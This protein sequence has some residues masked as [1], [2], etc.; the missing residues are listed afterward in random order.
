VTAGLLAGGDFDV[1]VPTFYGYDFLGRLGGKPFVLFVPDMI[2][3][4]YPQFFPAGDLQN[5]GRRKLAP[6][7]A[8]IMVPTQNT[9]NDVV[10]LLGVDESKVHVISHGISAGYGK[11]VLQGRPHFPYILYVGHRRAYKGFDK[12]MAGVKPVLDKRKDLMVLCTGPAFQDDEIRRL[13]SMGIAGRVAYFHA[14][15]DVQMATLYRNA[16]AFVYPSEYEGFGIPILEAYASD[17]PVLL[18]DNPCFREVA[19]SAAVFYDNGDPT[20]VAAAAE[21]VLSMHPA[22]RQALLAA[23]RQRLSL[24]SWEKTADKVAGVYRG[25]VYGA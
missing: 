17:C 23:Q 10:R 14:P 19:G 2:T 3:E 11:R 8:A 20:A 13:Q 6:L 15:D 21:R 24:Y 22:D 16:E 12:F 7:A 18:N 1:F 25:V 4:L 5:V 9:K